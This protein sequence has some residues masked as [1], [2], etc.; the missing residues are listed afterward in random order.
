MLLEPGVNKLMHSD[1]KLHRD[2]GKDST[3]SR[4]MTYSNSVLFKSYENH[5][6]LK[7]YKAL[8][9]RNDF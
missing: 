8:Q 4:K 2:F 1:T 6:I 5:H 9:K 7:A 3:L